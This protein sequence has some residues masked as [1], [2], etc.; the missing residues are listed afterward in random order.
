MQKS[1]NTSEKFGEIAVLF[2]EKVSSWAQFPIHS[3]KIELICIIVQYKNPKE[4][5]ID[6][7]ERIKYE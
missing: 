4:Y 5:K 6:C 3:E 2:M 1:E 7:S